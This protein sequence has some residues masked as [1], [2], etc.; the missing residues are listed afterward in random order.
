VIVLDTNVLSELT[1]A[2]PAPAVVAWLDTWDAAEV[3][4]TAITAAELRAGAAVLPRGRRSA[5]LAEEV[6]RL[7]ADTLDG[8]LLAFDGDSARYY[9]EV[10]AMRRS[11]GRPI[12]PLDAQIAAICLQHEARLATRN[13]RDFEGI[14]LELIDPWVA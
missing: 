12:P 11:A 1:R 8:S 3:C 4:T 10:V 2:H 13:T 9:G 7:L 14:G 5:R 6:E